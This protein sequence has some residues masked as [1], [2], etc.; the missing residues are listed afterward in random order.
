[1]NTAETSRSSSEKTPPVSSLEQ[2]QTPNSGLELIGKRVV[3]C[4]D[5]GIILMQLKRLLTLAGLVVVDLA[6]NGESAVE[7][8]LREQ[9][10]LVLMDIR[11]P[12]LDGLT[13][14][15]SI[16][17]KHPVCIVMLTAYSDDESRQRAQDIGTSGYVLKPITRDTLM[18][19]LAAAWHKFHLP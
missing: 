16:L 8:V 19:Q 17:E 3:V 14:A 10:D 5:E 2:T 4:E 12:K 11:M 18:P 15:A 7:T 9:P 1:M 6:D 13:A